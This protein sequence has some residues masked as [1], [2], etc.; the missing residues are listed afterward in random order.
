MKTLEAQVTKI[1]AVLADPQLFSSDPDAFNKAI[2]DLDVIKTKLEACEEE[3]LELEM[4]R[5]G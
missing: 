5:E 1:E 3:W 2:S 4:L